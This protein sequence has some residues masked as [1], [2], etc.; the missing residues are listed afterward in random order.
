M[1]TGTVTEL[2]KRGHTVVLVSRHAKKDVRQWATGVEARQGDVSNPA[3]LRGAADGCDVVL[4]MVAVVDEDPPRIT[5]DKV[6]VQGSAHMIAEAERAGVKRFVFVSSL[7]APTG[8]SGYHKSKAAA[9]QLVRAFDGSWTICRPGNVYGP[10]DE[11]ISLLLRL[12]RGA[13][14]IIPK[15]GDGTQSFQPIWW[16]D[17][18]RGI[19]EVVE[20]T[21][22]AG[23]ELDLAGSDV[24]CQND[25]IE[26]LSAITG[27]E[28]S[29]IALPEMLANLGAKAVSLVGWD[30]GFSDDQVTMLR[31]GNVIPPGGSNGL[32]D[33]LGIEPTPLDRGLRALCDLQPEQLPRD[34][35]GS[36][37][38]K[39]FWAD[40]TGCPMSAEALFREF[41]S[42][43]NEV[44][45]VFVDAA[46][47]P[48][49]TDDIADGETIT[50]SLPMR[51]HVQVR[52]AGLEPRRVTLLTLAGHP[53]AGAV[54]F[55]SEDRGDV[56]RFQAEVYDRAANV[57]DLVAMRTVGD[58]L[59]N[60]TWTKVVENV[61]AR[62]GG[63]A[64]AGVEHDSE[65]L[66]DD[67][68]EMIEQWLEKLTVD[69]KRAENAETIAGAA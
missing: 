64:A 32:T 30:V 61:V 36:L 55:L 45:P 3:T 20:R 9:E 34:G 49:A 14:P 8:E 69:R 58:H 60:H 22:L 65:S 56:I 18:A 15:L 6:N 54:R 25:L 50:L 44:T 12:V 24:T 33:V 67:E 63:T 59:Q 40:I 47:E 2:V 52:V 11:Q 48:R 5:F 41:R 35:V 29:S 19:A 46:P 66:D 57:L 23:R 68:A 51:G 17:A 4:H 28:V 39:R 62:S 13:S 7:G 37:K 53:L 43:F 16:E 27:R 38:R 1:G 42:H 21:D 31:E 26:R 10:G